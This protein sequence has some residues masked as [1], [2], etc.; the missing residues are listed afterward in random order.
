MQSKKDIKRLRENLQGEVDSA[1]LYRALSE[2]ED[3]PQLKE[4]YSRMAHIEEHHARFWREQLRR[5]GASVPQLHPT[6]RSRV[7]AWLARRF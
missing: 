2:V 4:V 6:W 7:L 3:S 1:A 5:R